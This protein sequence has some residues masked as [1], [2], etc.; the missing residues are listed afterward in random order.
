MPPILEAIEKDLIDRSVEVGDSSLLQEWCGNLEQYRRGSWFDLP[1]EERGS[2]I[3]RMERGNVECDVLYFIQKN[4]NA[5][6]DETRLFLYAMASYSARTRKDSSSVSEAGSSSRR[7]VK[8]RLTARAV[9]PQRPAESSS[10]DSASD[11]R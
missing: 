3:Q 5:T 2:R 10:N 8:C 1:V 9:Q 6:L 7:S 4:E 11:G